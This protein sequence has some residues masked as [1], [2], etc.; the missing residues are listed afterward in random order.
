MKLAICPEC[1]ELIELG[2]T[3]IFDENDIIGCG[4]KE[5]DFT[6]CHECG[7]KYGSEE[8]NNLRKD[9]GWTPT[10]AKDYKS[11]AIGL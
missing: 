7:D 4:Q 9:G 6:S 5:N 8:C 3:K 11:V 10:A 1:G 2:Q